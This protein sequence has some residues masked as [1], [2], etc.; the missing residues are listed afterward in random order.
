MSGPRRVFCVN[1]VIALVV[2][3]ALKIGLVSNNI[4]GTEGWASPGKLAG[5]ALLFLGDD[6]LGAVSLA[7][8]ITLLCWPFARRRVGLA[9]WI[10]SAAV[11]LIH[12]FVATVSFFTAVFVGSPLGK[13]TL[14][15]AFLDQPAGNQSM[16][17][18]IARYLTPAPLSTLAL[19]TVLPALAA[20]WLLRRGW[21]PRLAVRRIAL[22]FA[23]VA[24]VVTNAVLPFLIN[25][26]LMGIRVHTF[27]LEKSAWVEI[28]GSYLRPQLAGLFEDERELADPFVL[29]LAPIAEPR[30]ARANPLRDARPARTHV[31]WISLESV[32]SLYLDEQAPPMPFLQGIGAR[33]GGVG[34]ER[35]YSTWPQTMK[36]FFS[37][38]CAELPYPGYESISFVNPTIPC[39]SLPEVLKG[40]GYHTWFL[41]SADLAYDRKLRFFR[42]RAFDRFEDMRNMPGREDVWKDSW[43][44]DE[45]LTVARA[46]ELASG[47]GDAP[48]FIFYEMATA[49]HPYN[50]CQAHVDDP[51][52]DERASYRRALGFIDDRIREIHDG[53]A[54][55]GLL[56][57]TLIIVAS[58]H[59]EGF[60]QHAGSRSHGPKVY[61]ENVLVPAAILAPQLAQVSGRVGLTTSHV[62]LAPTV[63]GL[64]GLPVPCTMKGRDL[65]ATSASRLALFGG[66]PPGGQLGLVDDRWKF[67]VEEN[68]YEMLFDLTAD[69]DE[70][71]NVVTR[72]PE[73]A[74]AYREK[75]E[76]WR[77]FSST[78]IPRYAEILQRTSCRP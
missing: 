51:I 33:P 8:L 7:G 49:H 32:A 18:S 21:T 14:D 64:L 52:E 43:G 39:K 40:A 20:V 47:A 78:L 6:A 55:R 71:E 42:H 65:V 27:G 70:R 16:S 3:L 44:H 53:L 45:R 74:R 67:I 60:G 13:A 41:T 37:I 22:G 4:I 50:G 1:L 29:D 24:F 48:F 10:I 77:V 73:L 26:E 35:H 2:L 66:R 68:Q 72:H 31:I 75:L 62:D 34:F 38:F 46:L 54:E 36:A 56:E 69:P 23:A 61:D 12:G 17:S 9:T 76:D 28:A 15:L 25:G 5:K 30:A 59:G 11:H 58:D 63:L 19:V 57:D